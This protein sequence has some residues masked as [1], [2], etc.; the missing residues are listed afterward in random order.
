MALALMFSVVGAWAILFPSHLFASAAE[1]ADGDH[2][3]YPVRLYGGALISL[4]L[5]FWMTLSSQDRDTIRMCLLASIVYFSIQIV[6]TIGHLL[7]YSRPP[8]QRYNLTVLLASR[9][10]FALTSA[11]Y[12]W[13]LTQRKF[14]PGGANSSSL[15]RNTSSGKDLGAAGGGSFGAG[16]GGGGGGGGRAVATAALYNGTGGYNNAGLGF[17]V[18]GGGCVD[19]EDAGAGVSRGDGVKLKDI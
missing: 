3:T 8:E 15:R 14:C 2:V 17:A 18:G 9:A 11:F 19:G 1:V 6:V 12:Q 7:V 4:S 5:V 13:A 16:G 10:M